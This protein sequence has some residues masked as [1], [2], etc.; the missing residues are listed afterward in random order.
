MLISAAVNA[1]VFSLRP[2]RLAR[3]APANGDSADHARATAPG[4]IV[5][6]Q[7]GEALLTIG[8]TPEGTPSADYVDAID[9]QG[10]E[11]LFYGYEAD[12]EPTRPGV[13]DASASWHSIFTEAWRDGRS[14]RPESG[15]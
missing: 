14:T 15:S 13:S 7:N 6:P 12:D 2:T 5:V 8:G 1:S 11:D 4:F 9:G 3:A 10:R